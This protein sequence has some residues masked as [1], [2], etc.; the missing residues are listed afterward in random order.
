MVRVRKHN[1][2]SK[3]GKRYRVRKHNRRGSISKK[4]RKVFSG[5]AKHPFEVGGRIDLKKK[6]VERIDV[7]FGDV[8]GVD[9]PK[10][11]D[12]ELKYHTHPPRDTI[13]PSKSDIIAMQED[14]ERGQIIFNK[15]IA[16]EI[17][18]SKK[19]QKT[20]QSTIRRIDKMVQQDF[21][22][23]MT[24]KEFYL[25]YKP[26]FKRQ[27]GLKMKWHGPKKAMRLDTKWI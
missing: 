13:I 9:I 24:N 6:D 17:T 26:I 19:F 14:N 4:N 1:R 16:L 11:K 25:K 15:N 5:L 3:K 27:L 12:Y 2:R 20:K 7:Y 23:G 21:E 18:E 22:R 8:Y 10:N